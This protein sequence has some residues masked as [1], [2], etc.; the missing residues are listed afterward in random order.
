M[1]NGTPHI[2]VLITILTISFLVQYGNA[3]S[4]PNILVYN[5][6]AV[7]QEPQLEAMKKELSFA[8]WTVVSSLNKEDLDDKSHLIL[9]NQRHDQKYS[10]TDTNNISEWFM[11]GGKT[12]WVSADSDFFTNNGRISSA[13]QIL[14]SINSKLRTESASLRD[15]VHNA[16]PNYR[17]LASPIRDNSEINAIVDGVENVLV[18]GPSPVIVYVEGEYHALEQYQHKDIFAILV[19]SSSSELID[20]TPPSP[21]VHVVSTGSFC[22][23]AME[24][25]PGKHNIVIVGG[26]SPF[27]AGEGMYKPEILFPQKY[28]EDYPQEGAIFVENLLQYTVDMKWEAE[29]NK[30]IPIPPG[31][32]SLGIIL[33]GF[34]LRKKRESVERST[35]RN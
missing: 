24:L 23:L 21:Q 10:Q 19:S 14:E 33:T 9:Y 13:N 7:Q 20:N 29:N 32:I 1:K 5:K 30:R 34:I 16:D 8:E 25:I 35:A 6:E 4:R 2:W 12:I 28:T 18:S 15:P 17:L 27:S 3:E 31:A 26:E 22:V 11:K